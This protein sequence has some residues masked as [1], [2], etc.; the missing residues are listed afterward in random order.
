MKTDCMGLLLFSEGSELAMRHPGDYRQIF[1]LGQADVTP[2][3]RRRR[4]SGP[5]APQRPTPE[6]EVEE[7]CNVRQAASATIKMRV[8]LGLQF[9]RSWNT[10]HP[11]TRCPRPRRH[12]TTM[13][14]RLS[15]AL[16]APATPPARAPAMA[17]PAASASSSAAPSRAPTPAAPAVS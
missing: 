2:E 13:A 3:M 6:G 15:L 9:F 14:S 4:Q 10:G 8:H 17:P 1:N 7:G 16:T 12:S 11:T 5:C